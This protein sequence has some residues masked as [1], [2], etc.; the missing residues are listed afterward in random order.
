MVK[1]AFDNGNSL[2]VTYSVTYMM[3]DGLRPTALT[4]DPYFTAPH[5]WTSSVGTSPY[6]TPHGTDV[7][8]TIMYDGLI[9]TLTTKDPLNN[10]TTTSYSAR[11]SPACGSGALP[12]Q[13]PTWTGSALTMRAS[14]QATSSSR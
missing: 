10:G 13:R 7:G 9:R 8:T 1:P 2:V 12:N 14:W 3:Y 11:Q 6:F 4:S 5:T